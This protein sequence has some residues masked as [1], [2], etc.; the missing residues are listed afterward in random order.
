MQWDLADGNGNLVFQEQLEQGTLNGW[1]VGVT[2]HV[3]T[4]LGGGGNESELYLVDFADLVVAESE[5]L[6]IDVSSEATYVEG[7]VT[8]SAFQKNQTLIRAML[9]HDFGIRH[10]AS[11][12]VKTGVT[13]GA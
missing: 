6:M 9:A 8:K 7:G 5:Q 1:P 13:Y 4:N 2:T 3:P 10:D 12:A 11:V